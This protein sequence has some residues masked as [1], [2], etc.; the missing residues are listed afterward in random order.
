[1]GCFSPLKGWK[2]ESGKMVFKAQGAEETME[3]S[4]G[5]C[6]GCRLSHSRMWAARITHE[7]ALH[8]SMGG[9][10]FVTLTYRDRNTCTLDQLHK[11]QHVPD[12]W[13]L[14][15]SHFQKFMKRLRRRHPGRKIRYY[16]AGEYGSIC[17]HRLDLRVVSCPVCKLGRPHY[18][19][20][21]FN[22]S[23]HDLEVR[24][25]DTRDPR[26]TSN[27]LASIWGYGH[28]DVN[29]VNFESAAYVA[30]YCL[31]KITG[32]K[33]EDHYQQMTLD[34]ELV[35]LQPEYAN[36]SL[37]PGIG[38]DFYEKYK[39]DF[40]PA[41]ETPVPGKGVF[42]GV[43]EYYQRLFEESDPLTLEEIKEVRKQF[44]EDHI[45]DFTPKALHDKY[46]C[47][48]ARTSQHKDKI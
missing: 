42:P 27:H 39:S 30:R 1:M 3:V 15:R 44:H 9:N 47:A 11:K 22:Y 36:M 18:H 41:D 12:D 8:E 21:L 10:C 5:Q 34:G 6:L 29:I 23:P 17:Q 43:P 38:H 16:V 7:A 26:Y 37:K 24:P 35:N 28:V 13:S 40:F 31:K 25:S 32:I 19:A 33:A 4:C 45:K 14:H 20:I 48:K 2:D 46:V